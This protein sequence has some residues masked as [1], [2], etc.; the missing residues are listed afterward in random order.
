VCHDTASISKIH[1]LIVLSGIFNY[2]PCNALLVLSYSRVGEIELAHKVFE[3]LPKRG[4]DVWNAMIVAYSRNDFPSEVINIYK[5]MRCE[6]VKPDSSTFTV[7]IKACTRLL[8]FEMGD[9]IWKRAIECGYGNDVFVGSSVL[10]L[11]CDDHRFCAE[12]EGERGCGCISAD[13]KRR[14]GSR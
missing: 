14:Y 5:Q 3:R 7:S 11:Y 4:V 13:A 6:G 12:W 1:A 10:N 9:E 8:D 2:A